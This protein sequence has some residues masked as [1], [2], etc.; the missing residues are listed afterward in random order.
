MLRRRHINAD[1]GRSRPRAALA[2]VTRPFRALGWAIQE[3]ILWPAG[4]LL[5]SIGELLKWSF[6]RLGWGVERRLIWPSR[7]RIATWSPSRRIVSGSALVAVA[8]GAGALGVILASQE[9]SSEEQLAVVTPVTLATDSQPAKAAAPTEPTLQGPPPV[10]GV[11]DG[12]KVA[13]AQGGESA[14]AASAADTEAEGDSEPGNEEE[15]EAEG[16]EASGQKPVPVGPTAMKVARRFSE[17]FVFYEVGKKPARAKAIFEETATPRLATALTERPPR[18]PADAKV[19]QARVLNLVS[20]PRQA[21]AYT[22]S[23]SLL[24][25]GV[26]SELR[27]KMKKRDGAWVITDV[28]G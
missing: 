6:Q 9:E 22:V 20:G 8:I 17:A 18:L 24:R 11:E 1:P 21:K 23:A 12:T 5:R 13:N 19:P 16:A 28:R 25:V 26:T 7:E 27:L 15:A 4:D 14:D 10:F 3:R 2:A